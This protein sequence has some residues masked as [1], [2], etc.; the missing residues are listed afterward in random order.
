MSNKNKFKFIFNFAVAVVIVLCV[1]FNTDFEKDM[2]KVLASISNVTKSLE[3]NLDEEKTKMNEVI[4]VYFLDVGQADSIFIKV[5]NQNMLIDAGNNEDG[6]LL[7]NYFK[8]MG[9][10]KFKYVVATH[11]HEDHIGGMDDII[12]N[13][14]IETY[15][16]P[17]VITTTKTFEDVLDALESKKMKYV[18]PKEDDKFNIDNANF[19]VI[20]SGLKSNNINDSSIVLKLIFKNNSFLFTGDATTKVENTILNKNIQSDVLKVGHHGSTYSTSDKFLKNV[21]PKYA[22]ISV[23]KNNIYN[24]PSLN[25]IKNLEN[26]NIKIYRTDLSGTIIFTSDGNNIDVKNINTNTNGD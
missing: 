11:P 24:L 13:F 15:Y 2:E 7:V 21:S 19:E 22:V 10:E 1:I 8:E 12:N 23:G 6:K 26:R 9:I 3:S 5:G 25:T 14:D 17:D 4:S 18:I 16:M 20:Y